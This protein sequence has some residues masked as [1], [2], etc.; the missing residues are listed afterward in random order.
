MVKLTYDPSV[1][2][3]YISF[4]EIGA[5][6]SVATVN[7]HPIAGATFINADVDADGHL[8]GIEVIGAS[9]VFA[10]EVLQDAPLPESL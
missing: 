4:G 5:G 8:L 9:R 2:A 1:D 3:A 7:L 6:G 10:T